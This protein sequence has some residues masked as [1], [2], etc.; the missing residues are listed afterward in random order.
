MHFKR[1][2]QTYKRLVRASFGGGAGNPYADL[3]AAVE[4]INEKMGGASSPC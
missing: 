1:E 3:L 4:H 2:L